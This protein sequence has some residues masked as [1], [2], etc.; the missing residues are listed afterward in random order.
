MRNKIDMINGSVP[1][2]IF[3]FALPLAATG[4]IQQLFNAADVAVVGRFASKE[5]MAAVGG[6]APLVAL[7]VNMFLGLALGT[8][9]VISHGIG[10][11]DEEKVH[12]SV[13]TSVLMSLIGGVVFAI[14]GELLTRPLLQLLSVPEDVI[15]LSEVYLR[16]YMLGLPIIFLYNFE[17]SIFR[18]NG[19]T[20][21]PLI[22]LL[23][24]GVLNVGLNFLFVVGFHMDVDGV[25]IATVISNGVSAIILFI[26]LLK[27]KQIIH[28]DIRK[29]HIHKDVLLQILR[30]GIPAGIQGMMFSISNIIIQ[31][32][33][34][35]LGSTIMAASSAALN[36]EGI[37]YY[38]L[39]SFGQACTTFTGQNYG[40][41]RIDRCKQVLKW[42][43]LIGL[44][45]TVGICALILSAGRFILGFFTTDPNVVEIGYLRLVIIFTAYPF[46]L[47]MEI[48]SGYLR[49]FGMSLFPT[50][51]A[52]I[53]I[54]G[55][56]IV[57]IY[58][59]F[60]LYDSFKSIMIIYPISLGLTAMMLTAVFLIR[61]RKMYAIKA[62][63]SQG[64]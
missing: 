22:V 62:P 48:M 58:T 27:S 50:L 59:V 34:N 31:S 51:V 13:H 55:V 54:C 33:I 53:C 28:L 16:I 36:I 39:S 52:L 10:Q 61:R 37:S 4:I 11:G 26:I 38:M 56:R 45:F 57:W 30:I 40:A 6:N 47:M 63:A 14:I 35:S 25:A 43:I 42:S 41:A 32:A 12:R 24:S 1:S 15:D 20:R 64:M 44:V 5:A 60:P 2:G 18:S 3:K 9:V 7:I 17:A 49:G 21:T 19:D 23:V 8:N 29:L 46:S